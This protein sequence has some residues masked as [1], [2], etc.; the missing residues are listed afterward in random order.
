MIAHRTLSPILALSAAALLLG[1]GNKDAPP[2]PGATTTTAAAPSVKSTAASPTA[3]APA[4]PAGACS[5]V[6]TWN[7]VYPPGPYPF[8]GKPITFTFNAD[9]TGFSDSERAHSDVAWKADGRTLTFHGTKPGAGGRYSCRVEDEA[10][11][12]V[13]YGADCKTATVTLVSDPCEGRAHTL[14][15][16]TFTRK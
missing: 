12:A 13:A 10:K 1:C 8:S 7:G 3:A 2:A 11:V 14:N 9:G 16:M 4:S 6:G 5:M 15:G